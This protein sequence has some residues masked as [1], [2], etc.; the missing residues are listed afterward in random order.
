MGYSRPKQ[1]NLPP[2]QPLCNP[3]QARSISFL[4]P[5]AAGADLANRKD[6][7]L[8]SDFGKLLFGWSGEFEACVS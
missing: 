5:G 8:D 2:S 3:S 1:E 7:A 6:I 4:P